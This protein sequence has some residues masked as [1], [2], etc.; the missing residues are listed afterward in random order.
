[1]SKIA[2]VLPITLLLAKLQVKR[3]DLLIGGLAGI[4][5]AAAIVAFR[6]YPASASANQPV[7]VQDIAANAP[8]PALPLAATSSLEDVTAL[9][10]NSHTLWRTLQAKAIT[11]S[12]STTTSPN[13]A[14]SE[15]VIAQYG[16]FRVDFGPIEGLPTFTTISDGQKIWEQNAGSKTYSEH[17]VP[18][19]AKS[20]EK[21]DPPAPPSGGAPFTVPHPLEGL[22]PSVLGEFSYPH[23][24]AQSFRQWKAEV[25][26]IDKV[27]GRDVVVILWQI[28]KEGVIGKKHKYWI[29]ALTG[30]VLKSEIYGFKGD[31]NEWYT[32]TTVTNI[33]YDQ[34]IPAETFT[35]QSASR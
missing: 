11:I 13:P 26:G 5:I 8:L 20:P 21:F 12:S 14:S 34:P 9:M 35:V 31:W 28:E 18:E 15:I 17:A 24:L 32:Q 2:G 1:M 3:K 29:D 22:I 6:L 19:F 10:L 33:V 4:V 23:G 16:K 25:I 27:A 30:V 7:T